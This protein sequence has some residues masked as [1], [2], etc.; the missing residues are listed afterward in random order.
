MIETITHNGQIPAILL[1]SRYQ[2]EGIKF[3]TPD[4]FPNNWPI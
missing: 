3:F 4:N 1:R 2:A